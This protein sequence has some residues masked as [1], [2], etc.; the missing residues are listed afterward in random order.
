MIRSTIAVTFLALYILLIGPIFILHCL[1]TGSP[2]LMFKMAVN[3][4]RIAMFICGI[5]VIAK[6][7]EHIPSGAC[8]FVRP[9]N[10]VWPPNRI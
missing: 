1:L 10:G 4:A 2:E 5:K 6:G 8:I 3:G 9:M 7:Q